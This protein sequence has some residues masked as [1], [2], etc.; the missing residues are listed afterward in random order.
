MFPLPPRPGACSY[1]GQGVGTQC[2]ML[3]VT[4]ED[5]EE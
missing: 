5:G 2:S 4:L 1:F 3:M